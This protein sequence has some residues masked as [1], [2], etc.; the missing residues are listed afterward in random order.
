MCL[1]Q[2]SD[3]ILL[4]YELQ[5]ILSV[6]S[7]CLLRMEGCYLCALHSSCIKVQLYSYDL[8]MA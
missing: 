2:K 6:V 8:D 3:Q 5:L 1:V 4:P 7:I